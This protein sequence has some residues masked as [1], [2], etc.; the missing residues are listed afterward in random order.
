MSHQVIS[1]YGINQVLSEHSG[2]S[3][4]RINSWIAVIFQEI[5]SAILNNLSSQWNIKKEM[6]KEMK[7]KKCFNRIFF[8]DVYQVEIIDM[9]SCPVYVQNWHLKD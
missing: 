9:S 4:G 3:P 8:I 7:E 5:L 6:K 1:S 2:F